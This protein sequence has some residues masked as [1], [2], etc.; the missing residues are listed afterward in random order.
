M[1]YAVN[2]RAVLAS[3][4][5][6]TGGLDIGLENSCQGMAGGK[7][8]EQT[9]TRHSPKVC[10]AILKVVDECLDANLKEEIDL[11][12]TEKLE[13]KYSKSK[14]RSITQKYHAKIKTGIN[15]IDNV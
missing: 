12:I 15:E 1:D 10:K 6:E 4:Y 13:R 2:V 8:W 3:F 9:F 7:S 11:T 5:I 14:I